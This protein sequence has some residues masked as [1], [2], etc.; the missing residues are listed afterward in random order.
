MA[1]KKVATHAAIFKVTIGEKS[2]YYVQAV[3]D[4]N[5]V[6]GFESERQGL[7]YFE[8]GYDEANRR[9]GGFR[10][11][12]ILSWM[13]LQPKVFHFGTR[14]RLVELLGEVATPYRI[15]ATGIFEVGFKCLDQKAAAQ[16]YKEATEPRLVPA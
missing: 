7:D 9:G 5:T 4:N 13:A 10:A 2:V 11:G 6:N 15:D 12:A 3:R 8:R 1:Q 16:V 14:E